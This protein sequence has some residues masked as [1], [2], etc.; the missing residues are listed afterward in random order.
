MRPHWKVA[1]HWRW[2][3]STPTRFF[4]ASFNPPRNPSPRSFC[5]S[6]AAPDTTINH[7]LQ[8]TKQPSFWLLLSALT[9]YHRRFCSDDEDVSDGNHYYCYDVDDKPEELLPLISFKNPGL[10]KDQLIPSSAVNNE[11]VLWHSSLTSSTD[12]LRNSTTNLSPQYL[13]PITHLKVRTTREIPGLQWEGRRA[14]ID[15]LLCVQKFSAKFQNLS[16]I[17]NKRKAKRD[18]SSTVH[19]SFWTTLIHWQTT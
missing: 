5:S 19:I 2:F 17:K 15:G 14:K 18:R 3:S 9:N 10:V 1:C 8:P 16:S 6:L 13:F 12:T 11:A 4:Q 7:R